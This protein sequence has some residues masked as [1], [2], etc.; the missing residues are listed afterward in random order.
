MNIRVPDAMFDEIKIRAAERG[1]SVQDYVTSLIGRD[2]DAER[3]A[4]RRFI[5][6]V[7][8]RDGH[9]LEELERR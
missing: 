8:D 9:W 2:I 7:L 4:A 1:Q 6:E 3:T 5:A